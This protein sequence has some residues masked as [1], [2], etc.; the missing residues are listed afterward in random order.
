MHRKRNKILLLFSLLCLVAS[1]WS[2]SRKIPIF[3]EIFFTRLVVL[4]NDKLAN[5]DLK[6]YVFLFILCRCWKWRVSCISS[7]SELWFYRGI[8]IRRECSPILPQSFVWFG[9]LLMFSPA[10]MPQSLLHTS[11]SVFYS[12]CNLNLKVLFEMVTYALPCSCLFEPFCCC[13]WICYTTL[14]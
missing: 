1:N 10:K 8:K 5:D 6:K 12:C 11:D 3:V 4:R 14:L 9:M 13:G 7:F 2:F